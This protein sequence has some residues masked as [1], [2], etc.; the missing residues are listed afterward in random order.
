M[1]YTHTCHTYNIKGVQ[2]RPLRGCCLY[3]YYKTQ[4]VMLNKRMPLVHQTVLKSLILTSSIRWRNFSGFIIPGE[5]AVL[6]LVGKLYTWIPPGLVLTMSDICV[7]NTDGGR[8]WSPQLS[9]IISLSRW[10]HSA[11]VFTKK[12][13]LS[14]SVV[15]FL[16]MKPC[17]DLWYGVWWYLKI[18]IH[19][20]VLF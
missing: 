1:A 5:R 8:L 14:C 4:W 7:S 12:R 3:P 20:I 9:V 10:F 19:L 2:E 16:M 6:T 17:H 11:V 18:G 15:Q 13:F